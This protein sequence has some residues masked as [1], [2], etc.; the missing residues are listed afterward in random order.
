MRL[1]QLQQLVTLS[2][3]GSFTKAAQVLFISQPALSTSIREL[4]EEL[5]Q[6]LIFRNNRGIL[7]TPVGLQVLEHAKLALAQ[8]EEIDRL[9]HEENYTGEFA[10]ASTPHYCAT[11]LMKAKL[12]LE[13][14]FPQLSVAL[15][16]SDSSS[17]LHSV[18]EGEVD[19]GIVQLCDLDPGEMQ[20]YIQSNEIRYCELFED[21]LCVA[22][23]EGHPLLAQERVLTDD[24][25]RYP[26]G[27]FK[28]AMNRWVADL[29]QRQSNAPHV[30]RIK[31]TVPLRILLVQAQ[32][33][34]VIPCRAIEH[35]NKIYRDKLVPL[36][37]CDVTLSTKVGIIYKK[38]RNERLMKYTTTLLREICTGYQND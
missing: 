6:Q 28:Q 32:A 10:L 23:A 35:G 29:F 34:T 30:F 26:Y 2:Q 37:I 13:T 31:D 3:T 16:E 19:A 17:I 11:L 33:F 27:S 20:R 7:F 9:C 25:L 8:V 14:S 5:Q 15:E 36:P 4:E 21:P 12:Q 18:L 22:V 38:G 24:L 1:S